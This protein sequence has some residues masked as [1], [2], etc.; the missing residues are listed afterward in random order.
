MKTPEVGEKLATGAQREIPGVALE[1]GERALARAHATLGPLGIGD[2]SLT[3]RRL[4]WAGALD[5]FRFSPSWFIPG[6]RVVLS[7][8]SID[9]LHNRGSVLVVAGTKGSR[10]EFGL[11]RWF[12]PSRRLARDWTEAVEEAR[13]VAIHDASASE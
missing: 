9:Y 5:F 4:V 7:L 6:W 12:I 8:P 11:R 13:Q 2:L 1:L 3:S 10:H